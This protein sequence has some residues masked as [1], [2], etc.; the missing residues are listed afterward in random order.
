MVSGQQYWMRLDS[1]SGF[2]RSR[3]C[4]FL[5]LAEGT[6]AENPGELEEDGDEGKVEAGEDGGASVG[7]KRNEAHEGGEDEAKAGENAETEG[8]A[9]LEGEDGLHDDGND[10]ERKLNHECNRGSA[11]RRKGNHVDELQNQTSEGADGQDEG[12]TLDERRLFPFVIRSHKILMFILDALDKG[13]PL[14]TKLVLG[15]AILL[16]LSTGKQRLYVFI[17]YNG[18]TEGHIA[19]RRRRRHLRRQGIDGSRGGRDTI[20]EGGVGLGLRISNLDLISARETFTSLSN[21]R[22]YSNISTRDLSSRSS[23]E[24][25][26]SIGTNGVSRPEA[27]IRGRRR[28]LLLL[29]HC[30]QKL[31]QSKKRK[32]ENGGTRRDE[33]DRRD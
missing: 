10:H 30:F 33:E 27:P 31:L 22:R 20:V 11:S 29:S 32:M 13:L 1:N 2:L 6:E 15:L 7:E 25:R 28:T 19:R 5:G 9:H 24:D 14:T 26:D 8:K 17:T 4:S 3:G 18:V 21:R 12:S 23:D 16:L